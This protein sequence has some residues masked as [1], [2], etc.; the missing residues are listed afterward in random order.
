MWKGK[1]TTPLHKD[2]SLILYSLSVIQARWQDTDESIP[3]SALIN[4]L[5][6]TARRHLPAAQL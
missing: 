4:A 3:A 5:T 6:P 1:M 2:S